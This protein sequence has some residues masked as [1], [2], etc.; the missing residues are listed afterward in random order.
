MMKLF[1]LLVVIMLGFGASAQKDSVTQPGY[2]RFPTV[3][4]LKILKV[5][6]IT[7]FI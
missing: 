3:P 2:L 1:N 5:D 7:Y 4:P 6:S